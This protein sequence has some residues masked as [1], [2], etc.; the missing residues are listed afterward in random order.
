M[1]DGPRNR[2]R[3]QRPTDAADIDRSWDSP[4][5]TAVFEKAADDT[6]PRRSDD[7]V[8]VLDDEQAGELE[9]AELDE[10]FWNEQRPP[11]FGG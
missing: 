6:D 5:A 8:V 1:I 2:R 9:S 4:E 10:Q 7:F 11:H 3:A